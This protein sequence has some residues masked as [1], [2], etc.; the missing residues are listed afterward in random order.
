MSK[1]TW[2]AAVCTHAGKCVAGLPQV[3]KIQEEKFVIDEHA[4]G[5][6]EIRRVVAQC[7]SGALKYQG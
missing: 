6:E 4:A 7:P 5:E 3:F 1:V 2:D